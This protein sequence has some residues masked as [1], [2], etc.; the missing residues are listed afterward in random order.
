MSHQEQTNSLNFV[1][2]RQSTVNPDT[3]RIDEKVVQY[4]DDEASIAHANG[5]SKYREMIR[6]PLAEFLGV[7]ILVMFGDGAVCQMVLS[8]IPAVSAAPR[9]DWLT[10]SFGFAVGVSLG[11]WITAGISG[12]HINPAVTLAMA[13]FRGFPW[14]KV[15]VY[16]FA[17]LMGGIVGAA[18]LYGRFHNAI[19]LFEGG[20]GVRTLATAGLFATYAAD[21]LSNATAFFEE[22]LGTAMLIITILA[23]TDKRN[24]DAA[25]PSGM[26]PLVIFIV[27][28]GIGL[29][30]GMQTG[31]ALNPA[32]DLGPRILTAMAGYG[33]QV[34][35]FRNHYW[36]WCPVMAPILGAQVGAL[37][38]DVFF[39]T[40][41]DSPINKSLEKE[42]VRPRGDNAV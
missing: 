31:F 40:G 29:S 3:S 10:L 32:R 2:S 14:K 37:F 24:R 38:Y 25:A 11:V 9:G 28:L 22:F 34:F 33:K 19:D 30:I 4:S 18:I 26:F 36:I 1:T 41:K 27:I 8:Q 42:Q 39:Y 12:G 21:Y 13:T 5:W 20:E 16:I 23:M 6:A 15:P 7:I 17:Q 35:T